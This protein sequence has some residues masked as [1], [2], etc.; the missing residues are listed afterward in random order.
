MTSFLPI[1]E[2]QHVMIFMGFRKWKAEFFLKFM[3]FVKNEHCLA[4]KKTTFLLGKLLS[5]ILDSRKKWRKLSFMDYIKKM[6]FNS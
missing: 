5:V 1:L 2:Y 6:K 3:P 4:G